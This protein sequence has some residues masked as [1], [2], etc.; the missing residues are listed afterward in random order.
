VWKCLKQQ[1]LVV[2][3]RSVCFGEDLSLSPKPACL[4]YLDVVLGSPCAHDL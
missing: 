4:P 2:D 3:K 1:Q